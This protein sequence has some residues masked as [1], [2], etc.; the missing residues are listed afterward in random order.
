MVV[1]RYRAKTPQGKTMEG[2]LEAPDQREAAHILRSRG[3]YVTSLTDNREEPLVPARRLRTSAARAAA[4]V[5]SPA[6]ARRAFSFGQGKVSTKDL[7][8]FCR[9]FSTMINAGVAILTALHILTRQTASKRLR[10]ALAEVSA[11]IERGQSLTEAF[12]ARP[13]VFP[14]LL[15]NMVTAGE[16]G[17]VLE[18]CFDRLAEHFE[19]EHAVSQ[20][21]RSAMVYPSVVSVMAIGVVTFMVVFV[22]P[23]FIGIF[24]QIGA[25]LPLP[26]RIVLAFSNIIRAS[27]YLLVA[28]LVVLVVGV[29]AFAST[30]RGAYL[31]DTIALRLPGFGDV[32]LKRAVSRFART[33]GTLLKSGVPLLVS[34]GVVERTVGSRPVAAAIVAAEEEIRA[35]RGLVEPLRASKLFPQMVLEMMAVGEETG[36]ID[37]MLEKVADFYDK[38]V[39]ATV[40]RMSSM[41]E[42][43]IVVVLGMT[44]GFI[45]VSLIMP[46][47]DIYSKLQI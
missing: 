41:I 22:L 29:K 9:Q 21:V 5:G 47:F 45:L 38:E 6:G 8:I 15:V 26:T 17:G 27:W 11:A 28:G 13:D 35:G 39:D 19:K 12:R 16:T 25:E 30:G 44:V 32:I 40:E 43:L 7:S 37:A 36:A 4:A 1:Y 10:L 20:K 14:P 2:T 46:M 23:N 33:L 31:L 18:G 34:L 3:L 24:A 42:P